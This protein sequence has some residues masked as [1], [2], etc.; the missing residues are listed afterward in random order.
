[1][2]YAP[3]G[4]SHWSTS[5]GVLLVDLCGGV[6]PQVRRKRARPGPARTDLAGWGPASSL[7]P[8]NAVFRVTRAPPSSEGRARL[9][10]HANSGRRRR[11]FLSAIGE[12]GGSRHFLGAVFAP[13]RRA[14]TTTNVG[15]PPPHAK[16]RCGGQVWGGAASGRRA[17]DGWKCATRRAARGAGSFGRKESKLSRSRTH[18][19]ATGACPHGPK[20]GPT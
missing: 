3:D 13:A 4:R 19:G 12:Q 17:G 18:A 6:E 9:A 5:P 7:S 14:H 20:I 16:H 11:Q 8:S 10:A 2:V 15:R 1:M